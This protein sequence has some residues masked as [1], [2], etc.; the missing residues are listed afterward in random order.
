MYGIVL[1][2]GCPVHLQHRNQR[3]M[4]NH[5]LLKVNSIIKYGSFKINP[6]SGEV[7][8]TYNTFMT[9]FQYKNMLFDHEMCISYINQELLKVKFSLRIHWYK[10]MHL[11]N[12]LPLNY[13]EDP[14]FSKVKIMSIPTVVTNKLE[15]LRK[16]FPYLH[17]E[18]PFM[19]ANKP[20]GL[21]PEEIK[22]INSKIKNVSLQS[23]EINE[24]YVKIIRL[25]S[26]LKINL[27]IGE[28][29]D[30]AEK[31]LCIS[32]LES[33]ASSHRE[34]EPAKIYS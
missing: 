25:F 13:S 3:I 16:I 15:T 34:G 18:F 10:M 19:H 23:K 12:M 8:I 33:P 1:K 5:F 22:K 4:M 31:K 6:L 11:V 20:V 24:E 32:V 21:K 29:F 30:E 17:L 14:S 26:P 28:S 27:Q 7:M 9:N 2:N